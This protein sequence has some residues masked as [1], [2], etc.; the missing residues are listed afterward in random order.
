MI[1]NK[2]LLLVA[3]LLCALVSC[4]KPVIPVTEEKGNLTISVMQIEQMPFDGSMTRAEL[5]QYFT[6]LNFAVYDSLGTRVKQ[7]NQLK[8]DKDFGTAVFQLSEGKYKVVVLGHSSNGNPTMTNYQKIQFKNDDGYTDTFLCFDSVEVSKTP[9]TLPAIPHR[10]VTL[11]RF[12]ITDTIPSNVSR[13]RFLYTGGSGA[14]DATTGLG[15]VN[16]KQSEF[17]TVEPGSASTAFDLY[18]FLHDDKG[19][20]HLQATAYDEK[21][22][23]LNDREFD[24][25]LKRRQITKVSGQ[26]FNTSSS[27]LTILIG[28][29]PEWEGEEEISY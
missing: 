14:F 20:I 6:R 18:T 1:R 11:C 10:I 12:V 8:D 7:T 3:L 28:L 23:V 4:E 25:P 27:G 2:S 19:T 17:F 13:M 9:T 24:I 15:C 29:D 16:S 22:N 5:S 26:Y 21:D